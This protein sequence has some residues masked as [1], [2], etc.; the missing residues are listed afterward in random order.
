MGQPNNPQGGSPKTVN[1]TLLIVFAVVGVIQITLLIFGFNFPLQIITVI[2][3]LLGLFY[4]VTQATAPN[5]S[6]IGTMFRRLPLSVNIAIPIILFILLLLSLAANYL[7]I[8][9][10]DL[11]V[12]PQQTPTPTQS[13]VISPTVTGILSISPTATPTDTPTPTPT[14]TI[15]PTP[16]TCPYLTRRDFADNERDIP[17]NVDVP[18]GCYMLL[19]IYNR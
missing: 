8:S 5:F 13:I 9:H 11:T 12:S 3:N 10:K 7:V 1:R 14:P 16:T 4:T 18:Q 17:M 19:S 15:T 2:L 6:S